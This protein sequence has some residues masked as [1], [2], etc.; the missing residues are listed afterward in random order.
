MGRASEPIFEH[1]VGACRRRTPRG[2][3]RFLEGGI[4]K[5]SVRRVRRHLQIDTGPRRS[6]SACSEKSETTSDGTGVSGPMW[7]AQSAWRRVWR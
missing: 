2:L 1:L 6:P 3:H 4:G 7:A 5:V